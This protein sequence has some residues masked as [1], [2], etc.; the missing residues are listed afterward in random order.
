MKKASKSQE[1][2]KTLVI[3]LLFVAVMTMTGL[4]FKALKNRNENSYNNQSDGFNLNPAFSANFETLAGKGAFLP[5]QIAYKTE[6]NNLYA[7]C[8]GSDYTN[9]IY[10][11]MSTGITAIL[12]SDCTPVKETPDAFYNAIASSE[13]VYLKYHSPAA[14][15]LIYLNSLTKDDTTKDISLGN[16]TPTLKISELV[17]FPDN[18][19]AGSPLAFARTDDGSVYK[20]VVKNTPQSKLFSIDDLELYKEAGAMSLAEFYAKNDAFLPSTLIFNDTTTKARLSLS[21]GIAN[22]SKDTDSQAYFAELFDINPNKTGSY[23]DNDINGTVYP[24]THGTLRATDTFISYTAETTVGGISLSF[25][26]GKEKDTDHSM[27]ECI[28][29]AQAVAS[30]L[31]TLQPVKLGE[32]ELLITDLRRSGDKLTVKFNYFCD[33]IPIADCGNALTIEMTKNKLTGFS[34]YPLTATADKGIIRK[35]IPASWAINIAKNSIIPSSENTLIFKYVK[36]D[37]DYYFAE[38]VPHKIIR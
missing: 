13:F 27:L 16:L 3:I 29:I 33:N 22:L 20:F 34:F 12:G 10:S 36:S 38:W 9:E 37:N 15:T 6:N 11:L 26:S 21:K 19:S 2:L 28:S 32:A 8:S 23:F 7:I 24:A 1:H 5:A 18:T 14:G 17:I 25:F 31:P 35:S 30:V 4:H